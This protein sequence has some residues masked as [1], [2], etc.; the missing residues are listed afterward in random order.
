[1]ASP[2]AKRFIWIA[3]LLC[4]AYYILESINGRSQMAD[5]RVYY[6][7]A[8]AFLHDTQLY[9]K[10]FGVSS[11][12]YKYSPFAT[13][14]FVPLA[15]LDYNVASII[16]YLLI[17]AA[18]IWWSLYILY[19]LEADK[20]QRIH[21]A[22]WVLFVIT[23]FMADHIER[24][25]HL[26]NVNL[27]LLMGA[28]TAFVCMQ[29]GKVVAAGLLFGLILLFKPHFIILIP[30]FIWKKEWRVLLSA[31]GAFLCGLLLPA[32]AKGWKHNVELHG[33]WLEAMREHNVKLEESP[34]TIYGIANH[35]LLNHHGGF[36][37][38]LL[39]LAAVGAFFIWFL[40]RNRRV[41]HS[42]KP[43]FIEYFMLIALIPN[44]AHTD[45]EHFMWTWPLVAYT[46]IQLFRE[47]LANKWIYITAM[48][49]AFIP[50]CLNSPDIVGRDL[51]FLFD[52]GGL[53][54]LANLVIITT[55]IMLYIRTSS[56]LPAL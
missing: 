33:Q 7:A 15:L 49:L 11:G 32:I 51:R 1:M 12:F 37:I 4:I 48:C 5:F 31:A 14:P 40:V 43:K 19:Y 17:T 52:E 55:S 23:L 50:Y 20:S 9:G 24:E 21:N 28:F 3:G 8:N 41:T 16:Y 45:T 56:P 35:F 36:L 34:N 47:Q 42:G 54:G 38:V 10:A 46:F 18:I 2:A 30:Y 53:L 22:G 39:L 6:D 27:F 44:L 13:L 26:G 25:L 29:K